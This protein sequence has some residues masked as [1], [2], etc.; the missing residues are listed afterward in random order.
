[1]MLLH[2][3]MTVHPKRLQAVPRDI[4]VIKYKTLSVFVMF[5]TE[6][7]AKHTEKTMKLH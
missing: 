1:M 2:Q 3:A 7:M 6:T 5:F 4:N